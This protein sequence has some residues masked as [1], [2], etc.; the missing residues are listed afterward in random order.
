M[1]VPHFFLGL[2]DSI[3]HPVALDGALQAVVERVTGPG[4]TV[5]RLANAAW[6]DYQPF[7]NQAVVPVF[8]E[9]NKRDFVAVLQADEMKGRWVCPTAQ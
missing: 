9:L 5:P 6:V 2:L 8:V 3:F 4:V 1:D 7:F